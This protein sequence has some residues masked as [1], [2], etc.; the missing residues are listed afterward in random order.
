MKDNYC[1]LY[2]VAKY[3]LYSLTSP[4]HLLNAMKI[5]QQA[6]VC[7]LRMASRSFDLVRCYSV[8]VRLTVIE[9][10]WVEAKRKGER[11]IATK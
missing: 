11:E 9:M 8:Q 4:S 10:R 2:L 6:V 3:F 7:R 1:D 5:L